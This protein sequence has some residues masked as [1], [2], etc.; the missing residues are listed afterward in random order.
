MSPNCVQQPS[1]IVP[2]RCPLS[3][4]CRGTAGGRGRRL[5][6]R[7]PQAP[8]ERELGFQLAR[9]SHPH[10]RGTTFSLSDVSP[11]LSS[12]LP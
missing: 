5:L 6:Q 7:P 11:T 2:R 1:S 4:G 8:A 12:P 9:L 3:D 10:P